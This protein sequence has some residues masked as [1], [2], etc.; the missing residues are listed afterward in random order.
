MLYISLFFFCSEIEYCYV[1][2]TCS[3]AAS[4]A[5][6]LEGCA[7]TG[8]WVWGSELEVAFP[9]PQWDGVRQWRRPWSSVDCRWARVSGVL[10]HISSLEIHCSS[11]DFSFCMYMVYAMHVFVYACLCMCIC[12]DQISALGFFL[13]HFLLVWLTR[14]SW[15]AWSSL[16]W[17]LWLASS[18]WDSLP[19]SLK[20]YN[21]RL[22]CL[23]LYCV[24]SGAPDSSLHMHSLPSTHMFPI[25]VALCE[26]CESWDAFSS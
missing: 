15:W 16:L 26:T 13:T 8:G 1:P 3:D 20:N 4:W 18:S 10:L 14:V 21:D 23:P 12:R 24:D 5:S 7:I 19:E 9:G 22:P 25:S 11:F 17:L 2:L 6:G